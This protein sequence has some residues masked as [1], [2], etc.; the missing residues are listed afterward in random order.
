MDFNTLIPQLQE[1]YIFLFDVFRQ[2]KIT[3]IYT[4]NFYV[5]TFAKI[6]NVIPN[7]FPKDE[8]L[9]LY[10]LFDSGINSQETIY[11]IAPAANAKEKPINSFDMLPIIAP[12]KAPIP[13]VTPDKAVKI[14][15]L[16]FP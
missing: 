14:I 6:P 11:N 3:Y 2:S 10:I 13:V 8:N 7:I 12:K 5:K 1:K 15:A 4:K 16:N 9:P